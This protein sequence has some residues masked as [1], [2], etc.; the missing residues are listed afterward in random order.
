MIATGAIVHA[1]RICSKRI[2]R[3]RTSRL[4]PELNA[5]YYWSAAAYAEAFAGHIAWSRFGSPTGF[6]GFPGT[7]MQRAF[8]TIIASELKLTT[9][10]VPNDTAGEL[11]SAGG[12][13]DISRRW[14][15]AQAPETRRQ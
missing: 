10:A 4:T 13:M 11:L 5:L 12:A 9:K 6:H 2:D 1:A 14:S 15:E 7:C 3:Y 8:S